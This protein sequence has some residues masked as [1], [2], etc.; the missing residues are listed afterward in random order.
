MLY[1]MLS[2]ELP[3]RG[4]SYN[5]IMVAIV[6]Q[7]VPALRAVAPDLPEALTSVIEKA[8]AKDPD[9]R[10]QTVGELADAL[11]DFVMDGGLCG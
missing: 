7:P 3:Y 5:Q 8:L 6:V 11:T 10:F 1:Q 2:G 9:A 4:D